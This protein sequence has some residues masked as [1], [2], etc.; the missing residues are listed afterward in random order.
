MAIYIWNSPVSGVYY[1]GESTPT[2]GSFYYDFTNSSLANII[3]DGWTVTNQSVIQYDTTKG[4]FRLSSTEPCMTWGTSIDLSTLTTKL[5]ITCNVR[6]RDSSGGNYW[7]TV[8]VAPSGSTSS[9]NWA[10]AHENWTWFWIALLW[11][12]TQ[13]W[14]NTSAW[15]GNDGTL[16]ASWDFTNSYAKLDSIWRSVSWTIESWWLATA[17]NCVLVQVFPWTVWIKDIKV[18]RE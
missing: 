1:W 12:S 16:V 5:T 10:Y 9:F 8:Q 14:T 7:A 17:K 2:W 13:R 15:Y 3:S 4:L 18:E 11:G 6:S